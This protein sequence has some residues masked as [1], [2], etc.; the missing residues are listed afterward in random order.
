MLLKDWTTFTPLRYPPN[1]KQLLATLSVGLTFFFLSC[2]GRVLSI[3]DE[4]PSVG[5]YQLVFQIIALNV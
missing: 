4:L 3:L 5:M 2:Q 1:S